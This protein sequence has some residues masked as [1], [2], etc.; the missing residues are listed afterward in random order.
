MK[1]IMRR[2]VPLLTFELPLQY[3]QIE[4]LFIRVQ[5]QEHQRCSGWSA[6]ATLKKVAS[7]YW[8]HFVLLHF[9]SLFGLSCLVSTLIAVFR[10]E[11]LIPLT[12]YPV[13]GFITYLILLFTQYKPF[14]DTDF[15]PK[16]ETIASAYVENNYFLA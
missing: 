5:Y 13:I 11:G 12:I 8:Y 1:K 10:E 14:Y 3:E 15:L 16:L 9:T 4:Q 2:A 7:Q 6:Q